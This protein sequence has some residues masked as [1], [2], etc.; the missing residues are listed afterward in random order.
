MYDALSKI[1]TPEQ[2]KAQV[3][4]KAMVADFDLCSV[5]LYAGVPED[6]N[7][8]NSPACSSLL[9]NGDT[10]PGPEDIYMWAVE[11][12]NKGISGEDIRFLVDVLNPR[13]HVRP[14][15]AEIVR[16]GYLK[17]SP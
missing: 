8:P 9:P 11:M 2:D 15:S 13:P 1:A 7:S 3:V 4:R 16:S 6:A 17:T 12:S 10:R 5:P 14:T